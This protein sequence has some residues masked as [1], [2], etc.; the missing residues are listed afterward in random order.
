[1]SIKRLTTGKIEKEYSAHATAI[2]IYR[3]EADGLKI[4]IILENLQFL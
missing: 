4:P 1:M 3:V 2:K